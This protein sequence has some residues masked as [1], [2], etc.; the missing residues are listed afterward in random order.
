MSLIQ[1]LINRDE[2]QTQ[3]LLDPVSKFRVSTPQTL[4]DTDFEYSLQPTKWESIEMINNIPVF[5]TRDG[6]EQ[7]ELVDVQITEASY[8]IVI[9]S[10][11]NHNFVVGT[12]FIIS[13]LLSAS[14]EGTF[15]VNNIISLTQFSYRA[16]RI[17][18]ETKTIFDSY[19]SYLYSAKFFQSTQYTYDN[20]IAIETSGLARDDDPTIDISYSDFTNTEKSTIKV[21]TKSPSGF[22][23]DSFLILSNSFGIKSVDFD[24]STV[25]IYPTIITSYTIDT[26]SNNPS[27]SGYLSR[28]MNPYN[29]E[30]KQ[31]Y[32]VG[33]EDV[34]ISNNSITA[35][36]HGLRN[37]NF[38]MYV[39]PLS[40]KAIGGLSNYCLY[41]VA[42]PTTHTF[43]LQNVE[44]YQRSGFQ[45][46]LFGLNIGTIVRSGSS[47][48]F[49]YNPSGNPYTYANNTASLL[50]YTGFGGSTYITSMPI[51]SST[52]SLGGY[53]FN[54]ASPGRSLEMFGYY[55]ARTTSLYSFKLIATNAFG[56]MWFGSNATIEYNSVNTAY[57]GGAVGFGTNYPTTGYPTTSPEVSIQLQQGEYLPIRLHFS[58]IRARC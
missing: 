44:P 45:Y 37:D 26:A 2:L 40:D 24:A 50:R 46:R 36:N 21:I 38:V 57:R 47:P 52:P 18:T 3:A 56:Y 48:N 15:V 33:L 8:N 10:R 35:S 41:K 16:K 25:D 12:P 4:I 30:S 31:T 42:N 34:N 28:V 49:I 19:T 39:S 13:G 7:I 9:T 17:Q 1:K 51:T 55:Y 5:F 11:F 23:K 58:S 22:L 43:Q 14:A 20:L 32:Y 53:F 27:G 29:F 54:N 6:D